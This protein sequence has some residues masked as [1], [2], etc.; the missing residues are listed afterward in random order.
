MGT[1]L[2]FFKSAEQIIPFQLHTA[3]NGQQ[4]ESVSE[5]FSCFTPP[6]IG[7]AVFSTEKRRL[8]YVPKRVLAQ[9]IPI[10][11]NYE[12]IGRHTSTY[13]VPRERNVQMRYINMHE[14]LC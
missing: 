6:L 7:S 14:I 12:Q 13:D 10:D 2:D 1:F 5:I 11:D 4:T 8:E 9:S 3:G